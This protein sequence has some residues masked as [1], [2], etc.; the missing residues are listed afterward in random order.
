VPLVV[1]RRTILPFGTRATFMPRRLRRCRRRVTACLDDTIATLVAA[2]PTSA[3]EPTATIVAIRSAALGIPV[4]SA[5]TVASGP[6][7]ATTIRVAIWT[8]FGSP[9]GGAFGGAFGGTFGS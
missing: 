8:A 5:V 1:A 3:L 7:L 6:T 4:R 2:T 9:F